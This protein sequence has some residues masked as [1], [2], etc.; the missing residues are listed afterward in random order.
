MDSTDGAKPTNTI[1]IDTGPVIK[2][3][4]TVSNLLASCHRIVT[5]Q[6]VIDEIKDAATR[7]RFDLTWR[8][9]IELRP[10]PKPESINFVKVFARKSG[11][12]QVLSAQDILVLA[13]AYEIESERNG[14]TWR[15][16]TVPG[17]KGL[18]GAPPTSRPCKGLGES[19]QEC[20]KHDEES[21][22]A[23][24]R[25]QAHAGLIE[26]RQRDQCSLSAG[27]E[28]YMAAIE[29]AQYDTGPPE[30]LLS[31]SHVNE[32]LEAT[33]IAEGNAIA[34]MTN[35]QQLH[36]TLSMLPDSDD[37]PISDDSDSG[38]WITPSNLKQ[39]EAYDAANDAASSSTTRNTHKAG[40]VQ[41]ILQAA[42]LTTDFAMQN[43]ALQMNLNLLSPSLQRIRHLKTYILR[44]HACFHQVR[45]MSKQF[46]PR[47]G[48]PTLNRVACSTDEKGEF[49]IHLKK[50]MQ[51]N[52]R[53]D[54]FSIP[55]PV[56]GTSNGKVGGGG[57]G[58]G[59]W[60]QGLIL[61]EDQK[62]YVRAVGTEGKRKERNLMDQDY[63]PS[64]L[65]GDR[66]RGGERIKIGAGR[67]VNSRRRR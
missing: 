45:D 57:G 6:C 51:W 44:C 66:N 20:G 12:L 7:S 9:F 16:R 67:N 58:K 5:L 53:G 37:S 4:P 63:L 40:E 47:C 54:R 17:Q 15:L 29:A 28:Q 30:R 19:A 64:I 60:G 34:E 35:H 26:E 13:L 50:N 42:L 38:G 33:H 23:D 14:G 22:T 1:I 2:N 25:D 3:I 55:K 32:I 11:D 49:K 48:K 36:S 56:A 21:I 27:E 8:P 18:N 10:K 52:S 59:G 24:M 39:H 61:A 41:H 62:E 31:E 43:V 65:T 46:C